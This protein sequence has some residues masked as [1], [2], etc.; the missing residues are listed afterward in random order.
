MWSGW[1]AGFLRNLTVPGTPFQVFHR[2]DGWHKLSS[3]I[4]GGNTLEEVSKCDLDRF[5]D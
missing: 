1:M 3:P 5:W 4:E 2:S